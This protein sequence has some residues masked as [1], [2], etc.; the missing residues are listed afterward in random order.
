MVALHATTPKGGGGCLFSI[1]LATI[2]RLDVDQTSTL[3]NHQPSVLP[4]F[5]CVE[6]TVPDG[7]LDFRELCKMQLDSTQERC[8]LKVEDN[9]HY[10][11]FGSFS[12]YR[13]GPNRLD[14]PLVIKVLLE[15]KGDR[16]QWVANVSFARAPVGQPA[17]ESVELRG[18]AGFGPKLHKVLARPSTIQPYYPESVQLHDEAWSGSKAYKAWAR[19][20]EHIMQPYYA[21]FKLLAGWGSGSVFKRYDFTAMK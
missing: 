3:T 1:E 14:W 2:P 9:G 17:P 6:G 11:D 7:P 18:V 5:G 8:R 16:N 13:V 12:L 20:S 15:E 21:L 4:L 10:Y 19:H